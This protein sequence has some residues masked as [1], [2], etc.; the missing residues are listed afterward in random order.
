MGPAACPRARR[1][2]PLHQDCRTSDLPAH[3]AV[4]SQ[5]SG[6]GA[7][8]STPCCTP[9]S[10]LTCARSSKRRACTADGAGI[11]RF[12]EAEFERYLACGILAHGFARVRCQDCGDELLVALS[13]KGRGFCPSCTT[14]RMHDTAAHLVDGVLP[15]VPVRQWVLSLPRWRAG[16]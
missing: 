16:S 4:R 15:H 13:C 3:P 10:A 6:A 9:P 5:A 7:S 12:V 14:R 1:K 11:P 2:S 8:R